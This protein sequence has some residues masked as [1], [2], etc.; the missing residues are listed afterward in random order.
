MKTIVSLALI[1]TCL[2]T[3]VS[4][5]SNKK[6]PNALLSIEDVQ[7]EFMAEAKSRN[8]TFA[9]T[10]ESVTIVD[11][12][13]IDGFVEDYLKGNVAG[14][15]MCFSSGKPCKIYVRD[16]IWSSSNNDSRRDLLFHEYGHCNLVRS[17]FSFGLDIGNGQ[18]SG[19][20]FH[21]SFMYPQMASDYCRY[22]NIS[23]LSF[24]VEHWDDYVDELFTNDQTIIKN[25]GSL[26]PV[27]D[28]SKKN[29]IFIPSSKMKSDND[30]PPPLLTEKEEEFQRNFYQYNIKQVDDC[31]VMV[32]DL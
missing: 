17:H 13:T 11:R 28:P 21:A 10:T 7:A 1:L 19:C 29:G 32:D 20:N 25:F 26:Y 8:K 31:T 5:K 4:C 27:K 24:M 16:D 9:R 2:S 3:L 6:D 15:C 12:T 22:N 14:L 30:S 18:S 23:P